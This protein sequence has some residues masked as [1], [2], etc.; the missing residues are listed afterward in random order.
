VK[1]AVAFEIRR[2]GFDR[3]R[4]LIGLDRGPAQVLP[5]PPVRAR[6]AVV[7]A[8]VDADLEPDGQIADDAASAGMT[9][10]APPPAE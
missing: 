10:R 3:R 7:A 4:W 2:K 9:T 5:P 8:P 6:P 1:T